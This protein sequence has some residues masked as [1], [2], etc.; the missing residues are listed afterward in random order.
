MFVVLHIPLEKK[1]IFHIFWSETLGLVHNRPWAPLCDLIML[2]KGQNKYF[3]LVF[4][5]YGKIIRTTMMIIFFKNKKAF[6]YTNLLQLYQW[7]LTIHKFLTFFY[8][9]YLRHHLLLIPIMLLLV[10]FNVI[11]TIVPI[12]YTINLN[13]QI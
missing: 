5:W 11:E 2:P 12:S 4:H 9:T 7:F 8:K 3:D 13:I 6:I 1:K 10:I